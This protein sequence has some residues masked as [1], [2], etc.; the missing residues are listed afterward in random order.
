MK[1][2]KCWKTTD[3]EIFQDEITAQHHQDLLDGKISY[4]DSDFI[5]CIKGPQLPNNYGWELLYKND[6]S[7]VY[8][9]YDPLA[10]NMIIECTK[11]K[12]VFNKIRL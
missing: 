4:K 10:R 3:D 6:K 12:D 2:I 5:K 8:D 9:L 7:I 11:D 1:E